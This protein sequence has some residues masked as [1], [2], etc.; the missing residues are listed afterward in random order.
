MNRKHLIEKG[1]ALLL[2]L[3]EEAT[4]GINQRTTTV[5][6]EDLKYALRELTQMLENVK[7]ST[8]PSKD[9][10]FPVLTDMVNKSWPV[11]AIISKEIITFEKLYLKL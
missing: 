7:N 9:Q 11:D 1:E 5:S 6:D 10:M 8:V 4:T 2:M 3:E